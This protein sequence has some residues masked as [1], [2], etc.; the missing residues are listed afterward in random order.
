MKTSKVMTIPDALATVLALGI[1]VFFFS[2]PSAA[3]ETL[4]RLPVKRIEIVFDNGQKDP[5]LAEALRKAAAQEVGD[6]YSAVRVRNALQALYDTKRIEKASVVA[7]EIDG[8][9]ELSFQVDRKEIVRKVTVVLGK[10]VGKQVSQDQILLRLNL[11]TPGSAVTEQ[12]IRGNTDSILSFLYDNGYYNSKVTAEKRVLA[13]GNDIEIVLKVEPGTQAK[14]SALRVEIGGTDEKK[15]AGVPKLKTGSYYTRDAMVQDF[16]RIRK[17]LRERNFFAARLEEPEPVLD[18][19]TNTVEIVIKGEAGPPVTISIESAGEK[20]KDDGLLKSIPVRREGTLDYSAIVEGERV[21]EERFQERGYFFADV[22]AYCS[23]TPGF[24]E[25]DASYT[26]NDTTLLCSAL[27]GAE[28][29]GR[30]VFI[31]YVADLGSR[32]KLIDIKINGLEDF[33]VDDNEICRASE[34]SVTD[35]RQLPVEELK[36]LLGSSEASLLGIIPY[37]GYGRGYTSFS[38]LTED[39]Q[40]I[41]SLLQELGYPDAKVVSRQGVSLNGDELIITFDI[42]PGRRTRIGAVEFKGNKAFSVDD[43]SRE[44][45]RVAHGLEGKGFSRSLVRNA[46]KRLSDFYS[47][48]GFYE[49]RVSYSVEN[50]AT[51]AGTDVK[52]VFGIEDEG[53]KAVVGRILVTGNESV[54]R[55][56]VLDALGVREGGL[57]KSADIFSSEQ[58]LYAT[59]VFKKVEVRPEPSG[60]T[61]TG[62]KTFDVGVTLEEQQPRVVTY[63][64]GYS[65]DSGPFGS[66]D[67]RHF[68]LFGRLQQGGARVRWSRFRQLVQADF[69]NPRFLRDGNDPEGARRYSPL[70]VTAQ[71]QRDSTVTRFFRSAFDEG[72][73]GI[74]QRLDQNGDPIDEF[75]QETGSPT[76]NRLSISAETSRTLSFKDR[77]ILF[78]RYRFEDVQLSNIESLL[79]RDLLRPDAR[80]RTSGIGFNFVRDTRENC[81]LRYTLVEIV[82]KGSAL[83]RCRYNPG[84]ATKGS[85]LT[86]E[87]TTSLKA[88]GATTGFQKFQA[89]YNVYYSP[90]TLR[91]TTLASRAVI[92]LASVFSGRDR[93]RAAGFG[94]LDGALPISERFFGGGSQSLRGFAFESAGPRVAVVPQGIFRDSDGKIVQLNPFT[95]PFGGNAIALLNLEARIP[96]SE[97]VRLVPFYDGGN[98]FGKPGEIFKPIPSSET[99]VIRR[100]LRAAWTNTVGIGLRLR[101]PVGGELAVDYGY[102]LNPPTFVIPQQS[103]PSGIYRLHQG[104]FHFRFAQAF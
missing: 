49:A 55:T 10:M 69:I 48:E 37:L 90:R 104:Q 80:I 99:N 79:I 94:E 35:G 65:T 2:V 17:H 86:A 18:R 20:L 7:T 78:V 33:V 32:L 71:Y 85:Y 67:I 4:E 83:E 102:L 14:V 12:T 47:R 98:V 84:D 101:T 16:E 57:L 1:L 68:N 93:F 59:D 40:T 53:S 9:V 70:T 39:E 81:R 41:R 73:F 100:N 64:G 31:N 91:N 24:G 34:G 62:E 6:F 5:A 66:F 82:T 42:S 43:L 96:V 8:G 92:G 52:V 89:S 56:S 54:R 51:D 46:S 88:L 25:N 60:V 74:V 97:S 76:I 23:V 30:E 95:V 29:A 15:L 36:A 22:T 63:G 19:D 27:S 44:L 58:S 3:Q 28:L 11:L 50:M 72:T 61:P 26:S 45:E 75:G 13:D 77:S 87:Y 21:L 103:G 38:I